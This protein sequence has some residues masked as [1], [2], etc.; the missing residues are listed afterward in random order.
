MKAKLLAELF[1]ELG[2]R[3][4]HSRPRCSNDNPHMES[5]FKTL[6]YAPGYPNRFQTIDAARDYFRDTLRAY[7]AEHRHSALGYLT[8]RDV[9]TGRVDEVVATKQ[10]ALDAAYALHPERFPNGRPKTARPPAAVHI[11]PD[12]S[13]AVETFA[14]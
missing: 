12:R 13:I 8:P 6:K 11:N 4:S 1:D 10:A 5:A 3:K 9:F 14:H 2:I 7:N